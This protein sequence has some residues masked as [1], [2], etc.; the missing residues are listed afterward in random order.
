MPSRAQ[1]RD[2]AQRWAPWRTAATWYLWRSLDPV[3]VEY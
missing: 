2:L 3:P 1:A